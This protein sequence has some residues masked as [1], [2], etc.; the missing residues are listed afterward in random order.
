M[1]RICKFR[2]I[3]I[4]YFK[5]IGANWYC[6]KAHDKWDSLEVISQILNLQCRGILNFE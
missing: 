4:K 3:K 6:Q 2:R 5:E 1:N